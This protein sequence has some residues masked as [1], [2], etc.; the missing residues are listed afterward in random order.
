MRFLFASVFQTTYNN[1]F[2]SKRISPLMVDLSPNNG[3]KMIYEKIPSPDRLVFTYANISYFGDQNSANTFQVV[4][5]TDTGTIRFVY[6]QLDSKSRKPRPIAIEIVLCFAFALLEFPSLPPSCHALTGTSAFVGLN[7]AEAAPA[8][9]SLTDLLGSDTCEVPPPP[10]LPPAMPPP[11][12]SPSDSGV[13]EYNYVRVDLTGKRGLAFAGLQLFSL[14]GTNLPLLISSS[15]TPYGFGKY[16]SAEA[17]IDRDPTT[18]FGAAWDEQSAEEMQTG[19]ITYRL[20][21]PA[22]VGAIRIAN[23]GPC[24][25]SSN[26]FNGSLQNVSISVSVDGVSFVEALPSTSVDQGKS[27][28]LGLFQTDDDTDLRYRP[29][30]YG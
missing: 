2:L 5:H 23:D 22:Q 19:F 9:V 21:T 11:P 17:S 6:G 25:P 7:A 15:S 10:P 27:T 4:I 13:V 26:A 14:N 29:P 3:G 20:S 30:F 12:P 18:C 28:I 16:W 24:G 1:F 8:S